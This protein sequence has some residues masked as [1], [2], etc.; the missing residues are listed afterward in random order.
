MVIAILAAL[1]LPALAS[2]Q[3]RAK[4]IQCLNNLRQLCV[5]DTMYANENRDKVVEARA[6]VVLVCINPPQRELLEQ[7]GLTIR[8]NTTGSVWTCRNRPTFPT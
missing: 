2:A 1:L 7:A 8:T 4:R 5:V 3:D 6:Q